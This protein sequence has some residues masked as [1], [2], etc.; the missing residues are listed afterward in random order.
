MND[1]DSFIHNHANPGL[2]CLYYGYRPEFLPDDSYVQGILSQQEQVRA[3]DFKSE[4]ARLD[5]I[6][7]RVLVRRVL[8]KH[9]SA[10]S[11]KQWTICTEK[12]GKPFQQQ[13]LRLHFNLS[14]SHKM[15]L[16]GITNCGSIGVD[17]EWYDRTIPFLQLARRFF[18]PE[19]TKVLES[20]TGNELNS[21]FFD[22]W[23]KKE[24]YLKL[25]GQGLPGGLGTVPLQHLVDRHKIFFDSLS[26]EHYR[27]SVSLEVDPKIKPQWQ[28]IE[29]TVFSDLTV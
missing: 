19:E 24:A 10:I 26:F 28:P 25:T 27:M 21:L 22:Y 11:P 23:T 1:Q 8:S 7:G 4:S 15:L 12:S 5:Y 3:L 9:H 29:S 14:H 16:M 20:S 6:W 18:H 13:E 2:L 17:V